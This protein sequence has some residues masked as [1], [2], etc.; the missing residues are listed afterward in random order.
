MQVVYLL[1]STTTNVLPLELKQY[2]VVNYKAVRRHKR[3]VMQ[4][5]TAREKER[6]H[7]DF[8]GG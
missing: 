6:M 8:A 7:V 5:M 2:L 3:K 1:T 4:A